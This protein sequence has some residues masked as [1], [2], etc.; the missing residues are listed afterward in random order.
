MRALLFDEC[1]VIFVSENDSL[2]QAIRDHGWQSLFYDKRATLSEETRIYVFGHALLEKS[3][4]PYIGMCG[5]VLHLACAT[6]TPLTQLDELLA[7]QLPLQLQNTADLLPFPIL[8]YPGWHPDN[9]SPDFYRND[10]YF[11][12]LRP[13]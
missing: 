7:Q 6:D 3:L 2:V 5:N 12:P 9:A 13:H 11:R 4:H 8:G 10:A 1:G